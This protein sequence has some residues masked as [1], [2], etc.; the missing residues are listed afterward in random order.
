MMRETWGKLSC[1]RA[2]S[3]GQGYINDEIVL[4]VAVVFLQWHRWSGSSASLLCPRLVT[5]TQSLD[6]KVREGPENPETGNLQNER[7]KNSKKQANKTKQKQQTN[8]T[9]KTNT[10]HNQPSILLA[11]G[12]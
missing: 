1:P 10:K 11:R 12:Q 8:K 3:W 5:V 4:Q 6:P 9:T 7:E 2:W